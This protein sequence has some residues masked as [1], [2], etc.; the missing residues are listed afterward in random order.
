MVAFGF[1][2]TIME[3]YSHYLEYWNVMADIKGCTETRGITKGTLQCGVHNT[4][5][6]NL[7]FNKLLELYDTCIWF[8][9]QHRTPAMWA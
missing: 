4:L 5:I 6:W 9:R 2:Q 3:W 7:P 1:P 8:R